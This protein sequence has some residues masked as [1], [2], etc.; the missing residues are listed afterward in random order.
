MSWLEHELA[1]PRS[2]AAGKP[3]TWLTGSITEPRQT[4]VIKETSTATR[5]A[6][7]TQADGTLNTSTARICGADSGDART[8]MFRLTPSRGDPAAKLLTPR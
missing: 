3:C 5:I 6:G 7:G 1:L 8:V 4:S 2:L